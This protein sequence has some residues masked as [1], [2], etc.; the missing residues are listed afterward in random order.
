MFLVPLDEVGGCVQAPSSSINHRLQVGLSLASYRE[1]DLL[2][3]SWVGGPS[4]SFGKTDL[5]ESLG[6]QRCSAVGGVGALPD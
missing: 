3:P 6:C 1:L 2:V 4:V 5:V